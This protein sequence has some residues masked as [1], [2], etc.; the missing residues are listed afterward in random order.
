MRFW[1]PRCDTS[2]G[3]IVASTS[4]AL[5]DMDQVMGVANAGTLKSRLK[6]PSITL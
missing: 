4:G 3:C 6:A 2:I 5:Y 1:V